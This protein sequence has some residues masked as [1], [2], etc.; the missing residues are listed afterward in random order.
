MRVPLFRR[1]WITVRKSGIERL[2]K[3]DAQGLCTGCLLPLGE[4]GHVRGLHPNTCYHAMNRA[5]RQGK[6]TEAE[7]VSSGL[8]RERAPAGRKPTNPVTIVFSGN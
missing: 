4:D 6:T 2:K 1:D 8:M 3:C 7:A 5:I